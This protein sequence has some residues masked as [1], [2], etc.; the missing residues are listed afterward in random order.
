[1]VALTA[2]LIVAHSVALTVAL[3]VALSVA[4][5]HLRASQVVTFA[6]A[7]VE[8]LVPFIEAPVA[9][10]QASAPLKV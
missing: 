10:L 4:Q 5:W 8:L 6:T 2:A 1:M 9:W 7:G 3:P